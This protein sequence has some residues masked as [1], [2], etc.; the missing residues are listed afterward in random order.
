MSFQH[1]FL[2]IN[3]RLEYLLAVRSDRGYSLIRSPCALKSPHIKSFAGGAGGAFSKVSPH[4]SPPFP[5][6]PQLDG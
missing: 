1:S 6:F 4:R 5:S 2:Y 3:P